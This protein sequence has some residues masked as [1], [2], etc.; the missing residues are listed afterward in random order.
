M[1]KRKDFLNRGKSFPEAVS[2]QAI[3]K[4]SVQLSFCGSSYSLSGEHNRE[5]APN[6]SCVARKGGNRL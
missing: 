3:L 2:I 1:E 6:M 4:L 5:D